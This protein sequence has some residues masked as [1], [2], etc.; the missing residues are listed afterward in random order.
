MAGSFLHV[1]NI[2]KSFA[3]TEVLDSIDLVI[4][5]GEF[6]V[7]LGPS[8][9]GKS[10]LLNIIAGLDEPNSGTIHIGG[11]DVSSLPPSE[12]DVAMVFQSYALYP[13]M[14]VAGNIAFSM[15]MRGI[16]RSERE[17][18][19]AEVACILHIEKLLD[20][21]PRQLSGGQRQRVAMGRAMVRKPRVFLFDE[22]LSN[23]DAKLRVDMR[24]EIKRLHQ[25][26]NATIVYVTHDQI[27]AMTLATNIAV[28]LDG[29]IR[30][31]A[32]PEEIYNRPSDMFVASFMGSP[33]MNLIPV[34]LV[35]DGNSAKVRTIESNGTAVELPLVHAPAATAPERLILG[36]RPEHIN[37]GTDA[38]GGA[39]FK[40]VVDIVEPSGPDTYVITQLSG[41]TVVSRMTAGVRVRPGD[42][43]TFACDMQRAVL[44]DPD[45]EK[46]V[47]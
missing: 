2:S 37:E 13:N 9:C 40:A 43:M 30:Q 47:N 27:E 17:S 34:Q 20:R 1:K 46:S 25:S 26:L 18:A 31:F 38:K 21:K 35:R 44:F 4:S 6:L 3:S 32:T 24:T 39:V 16:A 41:K 36:L 10:T 11:E 45:T 7:L 28:M 22:P 42:T 8:G 12:R 15:E 33:S 5:K 19:V 29:K 23:L 14:T